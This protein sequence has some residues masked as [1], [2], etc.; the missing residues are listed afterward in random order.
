[1]HPEPR[2]SLLLA[3][4]H[5]DDESVLAAGVA[6]AYGARGVKVVLV[7]GTRGEAGKPGDPPLCT[8]DELPAVR[9]HELRAAAEVMGIDELHL[10]GYRDRELAAAPPDAVREQLVRVIRSLR[11][12]VVITFDPNGSN[13]HPDHVAISRFISDAAAAARDPRW[14]PEAGEPHTVTRLLWPPRRPWEIIRAGAL[15]NRPGVDYLIDIRPWATRKAAALRAHQTQHLSMDRIF[16]S[17]P[18]TDLVLSVELF[19]H[20]W[21]PPPPSRPA[22]DLFAGL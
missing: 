7:T 6:C 15:E 9:E 12:D 22:H 3:F 5:P 21:G 2:R 20:A 10:L 8:R 4:A 18:D 1:M 11:P 16:F 14:F 17:K 13:L 19:R